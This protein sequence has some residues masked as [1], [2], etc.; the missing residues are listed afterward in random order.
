MLGMHL[1]WI[2]FWGIAAWVGE[3]NWGWS[4]NS[5]SCKYLRT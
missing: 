2:Q 4:M 1:P 3:L 5:V